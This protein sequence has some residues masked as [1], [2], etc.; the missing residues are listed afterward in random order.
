MKK[1][2]S[3]LL[4]F[5][6]AIVAWL[7]LT[8][9]VE[10]WSVMIGLLLALLVTFKFGE[11]FTYNPKKFA[12]PT[13]YLWLLYYLPVFFWEMLK[14]NVDVAYR[15]LHPK[16]PINPG[17]VKI[18]TGLTSEMGKAFLANS[19][20]LTPGTTTVDIR[21]DEIYVHWIDVKTTD[22]EEATRLI[23][24]KYEAIIARIFE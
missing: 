23:S 22:V 3:R 10:L 16:M 7:T 12:K 11:I 19:I 6:L 15:V 1:H 21:G 17:L 4:T 9:R 2:G 14:A 8:W 5:I 18:K 13:R 24:K 20:T